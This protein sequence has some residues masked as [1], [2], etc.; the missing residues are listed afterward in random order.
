MA[1]TEDSSQAKQA[2]EDLSLAEQGGASRRW[3]TR[4]FEQGEQDFGGIEQDLAGAVEQM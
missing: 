1:S 2:A 4:G 3:W